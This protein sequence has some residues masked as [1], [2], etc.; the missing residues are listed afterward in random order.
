MK[1]AKKVIAMMIDIASNK[2][3][4]K[5]CSGPT[6]TKPYARERDKKTIFSKDAITFFFKRNK[7]TTTKGSIT[8]AK[9]LVRSI[10]F[11]FPK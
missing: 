6:K 5:I 4:V 3:L 9:S 10:K 8:E 11:E 7:Q 1:P 2:K